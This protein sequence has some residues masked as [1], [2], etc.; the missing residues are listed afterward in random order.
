MLSTTLL[1][2][3][4]VFLVSIIFANCVGREYLKHNLDLCWLWNNQG[5]L[6][7]LS[8]NV[9]EIEHMILGQTRLVKLILNGDHTKNSLPNF[10]IWKLHPKTI[11][12][13]VFEWILHLYN[14]SKAVI[15]RKVDTGTVS[16]NNSL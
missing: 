16:K 12:K 1:Y 4:S 9:F 3:T 13:I 11:P 15:T 6:E 2:C 10:C 5:S 7:A 8:Q 14:I